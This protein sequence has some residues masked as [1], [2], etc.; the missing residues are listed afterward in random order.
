M[1]TPTTP[2]PTLLLRRYFHI[3]T[4]RR[5]RQCLNGDAI[6]C[7]DI[8][9]RLIGS[10]KHLLPGGEAAP[11]AFILRPA[12]K[13]RL[14]LFRKAISDIQ[15]CKAVLR[16]PHG[17]ATLH[18]G[19]VRATAYPRDRRIDVVEAEGEGTD[20]PGHAAMIGL[21]DPITEA[22]EAERVASLLRRQSRGLAL[23]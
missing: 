11:E 21:P 12:D 2:F 9:I 19:R 4:C 15:I 23:S 5:R 6:P 3:L 18:T 20:I 17:A 7:E 8:T 13:G 10:K 1:V 22:E 14:S 16:S